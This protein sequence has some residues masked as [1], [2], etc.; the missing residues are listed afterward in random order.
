LQQL[1]LDL[2]IK[3]NSDPYLEEDFVLLDENSAAVNFLDKFFAQK[4]FSQAQFPSLLLRGPAQSGKTHILNIFAK[5][6]QAEFLQIAE[7]SDQ[8]LSS[9]FSENKFYIL[10]NINEITDEKLLFHLVNAAAESKAFLILSSQNKAQ[11]ELKDLSSR[12]KNI[13]ALEI[14]NPS[15]EA[16]KIL[17]VN[18]FARKQLKVSNSV[19]DFIVSYSERTYEAVAASVKLVEFYTKEVGK[20]I[21]IKEIKNILSR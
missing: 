1:S 6:F 13:F 14:K 4:K 15:Q 8:N 19:I 18:A 17:L 21:T 3:E 20:N 9:F 10:E 7:I 16:I 11:F 5:K 2:P 12:I